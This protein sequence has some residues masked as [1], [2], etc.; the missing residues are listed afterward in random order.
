MKKDLASILH[1]HSKVEDRFICD[2]NELKQIVD[3]LHL[4]GKKIVMTGGSWD[5]LH[6]GHV[7]YLRKAKE[8]GD[9]L[10]V[11]VDGDDVVR[12]DKGANRPIVLEDERIQLVGELRVAD[13]II[14]YTTQKEEG[15]EYIVKFLKPDILVMSTTTDK[16]GDFA[17]KWAKIYEG[18][19]EVVVLEAQALTSTSARIAQLAKDGGKNLAGKIMEVINNELGGSE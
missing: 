12:K 17:K 1:P 7:K 11:A 6:I 4:E 8:M 9:I 16:K 18:I 14:K 19:C 10:I 13:I 3:S 2:L 5:L 15:P